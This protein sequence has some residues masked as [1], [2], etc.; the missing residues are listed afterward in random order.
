AEAWLGVAGL[1]GRI[2]EASARS[3]ARLAL[4]RA[5]EADA[6][7]PRPLAEALDAATQDGDHDRA[8][9]LVEELE[10]LGGPAWIPARFERTA[11]EV[12]S[13]AARVRW[14]ERAV[15]RDPGHREALEVLSRTLADAG[16][17]ASALHRAEAWSASLDP[18]LEPEGVAR[19]RRLRGELLLRMGRPEDAL[20]VLDPAD[21]EDAV[22]RVRALEASGAE[23][24][25]RAEALEASYRSDGDV[26]H[27][28]RAARLGVRLDALEAL[29]AGLA[30]PSEE[31]EAVLVQARAERE[32]ALALLGW[33]RRRGRRLADTLPEGTRWSVARE[34]FLRGDPALVA[35][36]LDNDEAGDGLDRVFEDA[37]LERF[38]GRLRPSEAPE[39]RLLDR[40]AAYHRPYG[41]VART[42]ATS[43]V[44]AG[45]TERLID[46]SRGW[47]L[48]DPTD[49]RVLRTLLESLPREVRVAPEMARA[50]LEE[51]RERVAAL[52]ALGTGPRS[53]PTVARTVSYPGPEGRLRPAAEE[54][55]LAELVGELEGDELVV[56]YDPEGGL[57]PRMRSDGALI[58]GALLVQRATREELIFH[59]VRHRALEADAPA[60]SRTAW[61]AC[62]SLAAAFRG[63]GRRMPYLPRWRSLEERQRFVLVDPEARDLLTFALVTPIRAKEERSAR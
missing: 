61:L 42:W 46:A 23:P 35:A 45:A 6:L 40:L 21:D 63:L 13:G 43:P 28:I 39:A 10:A 1:W 16:D 57:R 41:A 62:G 24:E 55:R 14:L 47:L 54:P 27:L 7:W 59:C 2:D 50:W 3:E 9:A 51:G 20:S 25:R 8:R 33:V 26:Q 56:V 12:T 15:E 49:A 52:E 32:E 4:E 58:L 34:A 17:H 19:C 18:H 31:L 53:V 29:A 22:L 37:P 48:H 44:S 11:A 60:P 5:V 30:T 38:V 36:L